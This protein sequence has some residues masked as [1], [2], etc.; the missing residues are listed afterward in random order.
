MAI[1][2]LFDTEGSATASETVSVIITKLS[3]L[4]RFEAVRNFTIN[5]FTAGKETLSFR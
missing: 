4:V 3:L 2:T 1:Q 5:Q